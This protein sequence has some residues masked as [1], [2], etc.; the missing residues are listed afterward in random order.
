MIRCFKFL[1]RMVGVHTRVVARLLI[2]SRHSLSDSVLD[3]ITYRRQHLRSPV[4]AQ[5]LTVFSTVQLVDQT[6]LSRT[7]ALTELTVIGS[8]C[9]H[10]VL[11][12]S[13]FCRANNPTTVRPNGESTLYQFHLLT[14][15]AVSEIREA[16][17][18]GL[19][20]WAR[21]DYPSQHLS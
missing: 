10:T 4:F 12:M 18:R 20:C 9:A 6:E 2:R 15:L 3:G 11:R 19:Q 1:V 17:L 13:R 16:G 14:R 21:M 5:N 8:S 7:Q